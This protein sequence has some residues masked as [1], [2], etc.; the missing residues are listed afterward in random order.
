[1]SLCSSLV[2]LQYGS[3]IC[4]AE[5]PGGKGGFFL[6]DDLEHILFDL[7]YCV[8]AWYVVWVLLVQPCELLHCLIAN[9]D[10]FCGECLERL[11]ECNVL[12]FG[13]LLDVVENI[14][15]VGLQSG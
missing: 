11:V 13:H 1:M 4:G 6:P 5:S 7:R 9:A 2:R 15:W 10:V 8:R 3:R 14:A 12:G